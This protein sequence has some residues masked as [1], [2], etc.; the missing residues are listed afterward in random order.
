MRLFALVG[1]ATLIAAG[2]YVG[3]KWYKK[4]EEGI[5]EVWHETWEA[6]R[7]INES[8]SRVERMLKELEDMLKA[9]QV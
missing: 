4:E 9:T 3:I 6:G 2:V 5:Y 1:A 8:L 7:R